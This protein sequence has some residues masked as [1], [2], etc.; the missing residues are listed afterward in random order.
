MYEANVVGTERV[1]RTALELG[2]PKLIYI[3]TVAAFGDT[4]GEVVDESYRHPGA[5]YTSTY[6]ETLGRLSPACPSGSRRRT[7]LR[8]S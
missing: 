7:G 4:D 5:S 1:L 2:I 6:E 3:S 8:F